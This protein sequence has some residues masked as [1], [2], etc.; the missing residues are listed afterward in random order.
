MLLFPP[1]PQMPFLCSSSQFPNCLTYQNS[2]EFAANLRWALSHEPEPLTAELAYQ[3]SWEAA[4]ERFLQACA[5]TRSEE[6]RR[7]RLGTARIDERCAWFHHKMS[8]GRRGDVVRTL[9]GAEPAAAQNR[10]AMRTRR[11]AGM[12]EEVEGGWNNGPSRT[13]PPTSC[14]RDSSSC[15][16]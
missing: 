8:K 6:R 2:L 7:Q 4:T 10:Y 1:I 16:R 13:P 3:F 14:P 12:E 15:R 11:T 9:L 5:V